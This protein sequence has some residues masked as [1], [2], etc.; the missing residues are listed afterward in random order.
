MRQRSSHQGGQQSGQLTMQNIL[1]S[2]VPNAKD[3]GFKL[4]TVSTILISQFAI[5]GSGRVDPPLNPHL[6]RHPG[7]GHTVSGRAVV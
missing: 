4:R 6:T 7:G 5:S 2:A 3:F 1:D